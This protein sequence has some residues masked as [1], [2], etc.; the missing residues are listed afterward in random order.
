MTPDLNYLV[1]TAVL[2]LLL[3]VP[4]IVGLIRERGNQPDDYR[5]PPGAGESAFLKRANRAHVNMVENLAPFAVLVLD[6][7]AS[8]LRLL[9]QYFYG[10][11]VSWGGVPVAFL[12]GFV[13][14]F[15]FAWFG[16]FVHNLVVATYIFVAR[17]RDELAQTRDFLDHI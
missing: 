14:A 13:T 9:S 15:V 1:L 6:G 5:D 12:W 16:A 4:Y 7:D 10:Y 2:C 8:G 3:W 11:S 17:T